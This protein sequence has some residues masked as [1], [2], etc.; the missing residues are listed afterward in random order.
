V[1]TQALVFIQCVI[2]AIFAIISKRPLRRLMHKCCG[3]AVMR[4]QR[5]GHDNTP[6]YFYALCAASYLAAMISSNHSL[7]YVPYPTQVRA[8]FTML[9]FSRSYFRC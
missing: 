4:V 2:N 6:W 7:Q 8:P 5:Q 3:V 9:F 1:Y